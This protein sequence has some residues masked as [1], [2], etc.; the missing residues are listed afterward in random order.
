MWREV[1]RGAGA[2]DIP[3][4]NA[5]ITPRRGTPKQ[6]GGR[7]VPTWNYVAVQCPWRFSG[8]LRIPIG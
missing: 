6:D 3:G 5:C 8:W 4:A 2:G 1:S 7:V